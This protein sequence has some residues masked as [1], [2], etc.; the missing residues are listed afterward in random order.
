MLSIYGIIISTA[1][2]IA[3]F[4]GDRLAKKRELNS[5]LLWGAS[6]WG[7]GTGLIGARLYHVIDFWTYYSQNLLGIF[8]IWRGGMGILGGMIF[9]LAGGVYY[10]KKNNQHIFEWLDIA[11]VVMP[12]AQAIGRW[13]NYFNQEIFGRPTSLPWGIFIDL[14]NRPVYYNEATKFH[15]LFLYE[16]LL[17]FTLF[18]FLYKTF[19]EK[20]C[21]PG[22]LF[23]GYLGGYSIMR[24]LLEFMKTEPWRIYGVNVAQAFCLVFLLI[25]VA[26]L[27]HLKR[28]KL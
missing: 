26:S 25:S 9:G 13:G 2:F 1:A 21:E 15:P 27:L 24:F 12:L 19:N 11:G 7:I 16:S 20:K 22:Q 10:L 28:R 17:N 3:I 6:L 18:C 8:M 23:F 14:E 4:I 5:Y